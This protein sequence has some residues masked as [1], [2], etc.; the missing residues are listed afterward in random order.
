[1]KIGIVS[2][3]FERGAAYV[4][5]QIEEAL[6]EE[7]EVF[8]YV[9]GGERYAKGDVKWDK[10]NVTWGKKI[11]SPFQGTLIDKKEF[12]SWINN[13]KIDVV[14]FNEQRWWLPILWCNEINIKTVAYIDYYTE[15]TIPLFAAYNILICN[16]KKHFSAFGWHKG[17]VFIPWGTNIDLFSPKS[18]N[19]IDSVVN[20][21][22]SCGMN[23]QR[24]GTDLL[25]YSLEHVKN[26]NFKLIIHTQV[27]LSS[28]FPELT[29][30]IQHYVES[31]KLIIR[32]ETVSA[33]GLYSLGDVYVY[34]TRL[35]GIGLTIAEAISSGLGLIIPNDTP[36]SEF[37][38][39]SFS[40]KIRVTKFY[41]RKDGYY[42]PQN[43][44]SIKDLAVAMDF[45]IMRHENISIYKK[46]ARAYALENLDWNKNSKALLIVISALEG[47][48]PTKIAIGTLKLIYKYENSGLRK[49]NKFF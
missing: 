45:F 38:H 18:I 27:S 26:C 32:E 6:S 25:I 4:S 8:I 10:D 23:P 15:E 3:W 5:S 12:L 31:G 1:M 16:T 17:A 7:H 9:R 14:I 47:T 41:S 19:R 20:F 48:N 37:S 35:E 43:E 34:P 21:F 49:F 40:K 29:D 22:H 39:A 33:P 46:A 42:W 28:F 13:N 30:I 36:M 44:I 11:S 24:K 2:T